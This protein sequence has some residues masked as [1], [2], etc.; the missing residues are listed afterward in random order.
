MIPIGMSDFDPAPVFGPR[1]ITAANEEPFEWRVW[2]YTSSRRLLVLCGRWAGSLPPVYLLFDRP[3]RLT[4]PWRPGTVQFSMS[5]HEDSTQGSISVEF[6]RD[7]LS[8][9]V[10]CHG[11]AFFQS[12][13]EQWR[14]YRLSHRKRK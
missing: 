12:G 5:T 6:N 3:T 10:A 11:V 13:E 1:A 2:A 7:G 8:F 14:E 9:R 4:L